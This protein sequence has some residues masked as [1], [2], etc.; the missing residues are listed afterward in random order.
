MLH[1]DVPK[2]RLKG[3]DIQRINVFLNKSSFVFYVT[4]YICNMRISK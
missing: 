2:R 4:G 3:T 1:D